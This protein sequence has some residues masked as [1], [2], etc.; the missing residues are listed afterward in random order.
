MW[1]TMAT[2]P[3]NAPEAPRP[4][5]LVTAGT[6]LQRV[7]IVLFVLGG[8][9]TT[10]FL[11]IDVIQPGL[12]AVPDASRAA[13]AAAAVICWAGAALHRRTGYLAAWSSAA[14]IA[15]VHALTPIVPSSYGG[16]VMAPVLILLTWAGLM[17]RPRYNALIGL[18]VVVA[19]HLAGAQWVIGVQD[20]NERGQLSAALMVAYTIIPIGFGAAIQLMIRSSIRRLERRI[21][22]FETRQSELTA[23][24]RRKAD[25]LEASRAQLLQAQK[26]QTVGTMASGL[27]HELNNILTPVRGLAELLVGGVSS[28]Q[29]ARYGQRI[30]DSA[31]SAA[32]ITG[33][34]LTYTRQGT[35]QPV[36]SNA[37]QLLQGQ[38]LPVLSKSLPRGVWLR[39]DLARNV[40]IDVDRVLFQQCIT[41]L[42]FNAVDAMPG[43]GEIQIA[44]A[45]SSKSC[46]DETDPKD[47]T[48]RSVEI[49]VSDQGVGIPDEHITRIFDPFFTTKGVGAGTGLGLAMVQGTVE[50]HGGSVEV[51]SKPNQGTT[52]TLR[53]PLTDVDSSANANS[54]LLKG[55]PK[56]PLVIVVTEDDDALDEFEELLVTTECSPLCT[57]DAKAARNLL[58]E[59][60]DRVSLLILDLDIEA[61]DA[62]I[63]FRSVREMLPEL[64]VVLTSEEAIGPVIQRMIGAGPT[65][66]VR[67]PVD[68]Q[69]FAT[70][71]TDLLHPETT[72]ARDFTP[73]P[74]AT[75]S[76]GRGNR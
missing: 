10:G 11:V 47:G 62:K 25:E 35:F 14:A 40:S 50:R 19:F 34:L 69:L 56:G 64:P 65:R 55:E 3:A 9:V 41:N 30:L 33:A 27:A 60:G 61:V 39:V 48:P 16:A 67:K 37:R 59:V 28:D 2:G 4:E 31:V 17:I 36:R 20:M 7:A 13:I 21:R 53:F 23:S 75:K 68:P 42:V 32:Q 70:L 43:G 74:V 5:E 1:L 22:G 71:L 51:E 73:V 66:S 63:M 52:F 15:G 6:Y 76:A 44:L 72:Y 57:T 54:P 58:T 45:T 29:S 24:L 26:L 12:A 46:E 18:Y 49:T 38:I 8:I